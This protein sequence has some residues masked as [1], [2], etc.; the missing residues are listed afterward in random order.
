[1]AAG[2][3]TTAEAAYTKLKLGATAVQLYTGLVYHGPTLNKQ[4]LTGLLE[5]MER[6]GIADVHALG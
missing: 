5:L 6:D 3:V 1:M 4:I 2:G